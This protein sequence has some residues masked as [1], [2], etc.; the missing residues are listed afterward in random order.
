MDKPAFLSHFYILG[1]I[2]LTVYGQIV[3]KWQVG[4]AGAV[5]GDLLG[6]AAFLWS[7]ALRPWV[8]SSLVAAVAAFLCWV[9][10]MSRFEIGY[11]YPFTSMAFLI[12]MLLGVVL[13]GETLSTTRV[14][15]TVLIVA[16]IIVLSRGWQG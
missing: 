1:T 15:G 10:A 11:A 2:L 9:M 13:F 12:V 14:M 5:P 7:F 8:M 6:K 3:I 16:G 4:L